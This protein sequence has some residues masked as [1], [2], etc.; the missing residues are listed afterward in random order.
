MAAPAVY[1]QATR[2]W[3]SGVGDDANPCSRTAPC[4]TFAGAIS[5]TA[6]GGEINVLDPGGFGAVTITKAMTIIG[7]PFTAGV[8][9]VG[10]PGVTVNAGANDLVVIKGLDFDG[11][12]GGSPGTKGIQ[13]FQAGRVVIEDCQ[14]AEFSPR[15]ISVEPTT[16]P[17]QVYISNTRLQGGVSNGIVVQPAS[18]AIRAQVTLNNVEIAEN[19][20]FG[21]SVTAGGSV[22]V[23]NSTISDNGFSTGLSNI[24]VDGTGGTATVDLDNVTVSGS[25]TG[26]IALNGATV[27]VNN[28]SIVQ[29]GTGLSQSGGSI[30]SFG[31]NRLTGNTIN[32]SFSSTIGL[33]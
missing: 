11:V 8:L 16:N 23:R 17:V 1:A 6:A 30:V 19:T 24:R 14:I 22:V 27:R 28:S 2:T 9:V 7:S 25:A 33:Q 29:N 13:I 3:V 10:S 15:A 20:N 18:G 26:I 5:K 4:K 12:G 32:G 21:L 31:N